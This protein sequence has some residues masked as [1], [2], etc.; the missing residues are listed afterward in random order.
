MNTLAS[1]CARDIQTDD[2]MREGVFAILGG[3]HVVMFKD[4]S[5][6]LK[7]SIDEMTVYDVMQRH[8]YEPYAFPTVGAEK[9][10]WNLR[11]GLPSGLFIGG[12]G[13]SYHIVSF[14]GWES[15]NGDP[16]VEHPRFIEVEDVTKAVQACNEAEK[17]SDEDLE[18]A[19]AFM[20]KNSHTEE[21]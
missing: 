2:L 16:M 3:D 4:G 18:A 6:L 14:T 17:I 12:H 7:A 19:S 9:T 15:K 13:K 8:N 20:D 21:Q 11:H 10:F 5:M 1:V